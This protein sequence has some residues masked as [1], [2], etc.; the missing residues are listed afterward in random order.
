LTL[1]NEK[2]SYQPRISLLEGLTLTLQR[3]PRFSKEPARQ[4]QSQ[5]NQP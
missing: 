5:P 1:A 3:D 4:L 2:L